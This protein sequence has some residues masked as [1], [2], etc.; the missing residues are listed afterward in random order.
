MSF[1]KVSLKVCLQEYP[2]AVPPDPGSLQ[3][4]CAHLCHT[5]LAWLLLLPPA[6]VLAVLGLLG[7]RFQQS[8]RSCVQTSIYKWGK[9]TSAKYLRSFHHVYILVS[10]LPRCTLLSL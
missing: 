9:P 6:R 2:G 10:C 7:T 4:L 8:P 5:P 3:H 1:L